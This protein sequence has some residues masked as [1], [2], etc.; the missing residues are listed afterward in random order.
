MRYLHLAQRAPITK[1]PT[2]TSTTTPTAA[3]AV[4]AAIQ[5]GTLGADSRGC[6][7]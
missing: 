4:G 7:V 3:G 2:T 5:A 1:C 6:E